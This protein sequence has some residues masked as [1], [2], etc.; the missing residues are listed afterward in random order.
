MNENILICKDIICNLLDIKSS[1][2]NETRK[3]N[4]IEVI[5]FN[6]NELPNDAIY[7]NK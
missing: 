2:I 6:Y 3:N 1:N 5:Y 4:K 7:F